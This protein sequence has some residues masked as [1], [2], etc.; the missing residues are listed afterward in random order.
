MALFPVMT[1][2]YPV[3]DKFVFR[4][5]LLERTLYIYALY[6][7]PIVQRCVSRMTPLRE[8]SGAASRR[9][10]A[11]RD[12]KNAKQLPGPMRANPFTV[13]AFPITS[14]IMLATIIPGNTLPS[15]KSPHFHKSLPFFRP[16]PPASLFPRILDGVLARNYE[17]R[18]AFLQWE[19]DKRV[20]S[21]EMF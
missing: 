4:F 7:A 8:I 6:G 16:P 14:P 5:S 15:Q 13:D 19:R 10:A 3:G 2:R 1:V 9:G 12:I 17:T 20:N 21:L 11:R 18:R